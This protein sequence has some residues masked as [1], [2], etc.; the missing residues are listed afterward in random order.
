MAA[1]QAA[2]SQSPPPPA[3]SQPLLSLR[4][5]SPL[6]GLKSLEFELSDDFDY[7]RPGGKVDPDS[8]LWLRG[9]TRLEKLEVCGVWGATGFEHERPM[10]AALPRLP[11]PSNVLSSD[12]HA[13]RTRIRSLPPP[14]S[15]AV[16]QCLAAQSLQWA[17]D[18]LLQ[19]LRA[20]E[21]WALATKPVA[22]LQPPV[23]QVLW[24]LAWQLVLGV[25]QVLWWGV[26]QL[27][28]R[29]HM[30]LQAVLR[31]W[32]QLPQQ[33]QLL[34]QTVLLWCQ[35]LLRRVQQWDVQARQRG[36]AYYRWGGGG[37]GIWLLRRRMELERQTY[38]ERIHDVPPI[39]NLLF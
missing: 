18:W 32:Q 12:T 10:L 20:W 22:R 35:Q 23:W 9:L 19:Q 2:S 1:G 5:L 29:A 38:G 13:Q 26:Q 14:A 24:F 31:G 27:P 8:L 21:Q 39:D 16:I 17:E 36:R 30:L 25:M 4:P 34:V 37:V 11:V 3:P 6:T 15:A 28:Q 7:D 33:V